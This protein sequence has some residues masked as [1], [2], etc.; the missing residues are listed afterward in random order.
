MSLSTNIN[1]YIHVKPILDAAVAHGGGRYRLES[2]KAAIRWRLH[3]YQ[4]RK[5]VAQSG[6]TNYDKLILRVE[7]S[8]VIFGVDAIEGIFTRPDG[9][10]EPLVKRQPEPDDALL[11]FAKNF[12]GGLGDLEV[13]DDK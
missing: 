2:N 4:Y 3:A 9:S 7:G 5:L 6:P 10:M 8:V 13:E 12:A 1:A 11:D